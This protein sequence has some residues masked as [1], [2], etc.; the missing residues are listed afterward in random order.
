MALIESDTTAL[1]LIFLLFSSLI[2]ST[3]DSF[4]V[5]YT[6]E[7]L[8]LLRPSPVDSFVDPNVRNFDGIFVNR[9]NSSEA[10]QP[11]PRKRGKRGGK[12]VKLRGKS[13]RAP[14]P[15]I[16]L[17]NVQRLYNKRDE[18]FA[19]IANFR[20]YKDCNVF[21]FSET[22]L[23]S[24]H[25]DAAFQPPGFSISRHDRD[26]HITNKSQGGGVC[27]L[28]ND[29]WCTDVRIIS[30]G[31]SPDLEHLTIKCRPFYLPREFSSVTLTA[32]YIHPRAD[33]TTA[34]DSL[35]DI[36]S[37]YENSDPGTLSIV[38]GDF[39][40]ANLRSSLPEF[41]QYVTCPTRNDRT[42]D[43]CYCKV[44]NAF[45]SV[46]RASFG[47]SDHATVL[48]IPVYKQQLKQS[49][50]AQRTVKVWSPAAIDEL[51]D[52][53]VDTDWDVFRADNDLHSY[54]ETVIDY[55][56]FCEE[57]CIP[58]KTV[59]SYPNNKPWCNKA[60]QSK[61]RAKD[62]AYRNKDS[63]PDLF[64]QAKLDLKRAVRDAKKS[65]K[66]VIEEKFSSTNSS[67]A[68]ANIGL[69][70]NYKGPKKTVVCDDV[71]LP[72]QLNDFYGRF[73]RT[74]TSQPNPACTDDVTAPFRVS[75]SS[76]ER[77]FSRQ[78]VKKAAGPDG[79]TPRLLR[80]CAAQLAKVFTIIFNWSL[81][82][83]QVPVCFKEA[84]I[85]PVPKKKNISCLNDYRPV[86]L[87]SVPMKELERHVL[88]FLKSKIPSD[89]DPF[90]FA[91]RTNRSVEDAICI[92][93]H[94]I[95]SHLE[96]TCSYARILFIDYSSAF[97]TIIPSKLHF[98]LVN[99]L[100]LPLA[101][102]DWI[103]DF[104]LERK[105]SVVIGNNKSDCVILNTG[106]PQ[107]CVLS[108]LLYSLFTHDCRPNFPNTLIL[109]FADDTTVPGFIS[110]ND[111]TNYRNE[112]NS[113]VKWCDDN[114][115][116]LNVDKTKELIVDFRKNQNSKEPLVING[117]VVE[118]VHSFKLL[119]TQLSASL[120][121]TVNSEEILKKSRQRIYF[122]RTLRSYGVSQTTLVNFYRAVIE[123]IL[124][125]SIIVWFGKINQKDLKKL[126]AV[127]RCAE[128][129]IGTGLPSL[130]SI[131]QDRATKRTVSIMKDNHHPAHQYFK[132]LRSGR[133]LETLKGNKRFTS[134]FYPLA[135]KMFNAHK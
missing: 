49:K 14:L 111:E 24:E 120:S 75:S 82:I 110:N 109:K 64:R 83:R 118:Q 36:I 6:R 121:W 29:K 74:N 93:L 2:L 91:Y 59:T 4:T 57:T 105:Q 50:P 12:L 52:C 86:A 71:T 15:S 99:H 47:N 101:I 41:K 112:V 21:C 34:I 81:S 56:R 128:K 84:T 23:T 95:M 7:E 60:I 33:T 106:A 31:T 94:E 18:V 27:F 78:K 66:D 42:L 97:N 3:V 132:Y 119:G 38:S 61:I 32:V 67:D 19:R 69:I 35:R 55:V 123:S 68:W 39:N 130:Q 16:I 115:L 54:T 45:K 102:C 134:S 124:S 77:S 1:A 25:P 107:G 58:T 5:E 114:N 65:Q 89:F 8:L 129:I 10:T 92:L 43:H 135:V 22:W 13:S 9:I 28:I 44:K 131:H 127:I 133:R 40:Q 72:N 104:L 122:L 103:L 62:A 126:E 87:T 17:S 108:P 26:R 125:S 20:D 98:K 88:N 63:E 116:I 113:I 90:Q 70:T 46:T 80:S 53:F 117:R 30:Q 48:L 96:K 11:R 73:D 37:K 85:I 100:K 76:V 79:L 51:Q